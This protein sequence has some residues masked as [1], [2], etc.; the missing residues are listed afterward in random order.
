M[1][2]FRSLISELGTLTMN[3]MQVSEDD[4]TFQLMT[5]PTALQQR[6]FELLGVSP[7]L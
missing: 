2:S 3:T 5:Q 4:D 1:H 6:C 7:R